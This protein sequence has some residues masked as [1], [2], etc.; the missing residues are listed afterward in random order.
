VRHVPFGI[1][2]ALLMFGAIASSAGAEGTRVPVAPAGPC[3]T[4]PERDPCAGGACKRQ[5]VRIQER[6]HPG[7]VAGAA[8]TASDAPPEL[9]S[10]SGP[11]SCAD[12]SAGCG[13]PGFRN[14]IASNDP[15]PGSA[16]TL[17]GTPPPVAPPPT[18][19]GG[20]PPILPP[21]PPPAP[22]AAPPPAPPSP[23]VVVEP[24]PG[25]ALPPGVP[26]PTP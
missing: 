4:A 5:H 19:G 22:P 1:A 17:P 16:A 20:G 23:P 6:F 2:A 9:P 14:Q 26:N 7:D 21:P 15:L 3:A 11:G 18:S 24:P 10:F 25:P 8:E 13:T 12:P